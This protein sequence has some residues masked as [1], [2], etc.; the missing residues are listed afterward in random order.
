MAQSFDSIV[1][2]FL[3]YRVVSRFSF[4]V[5]IYVVALVAA[6]FSFWEIGG[7]LFAYGIATMAFGGAAQRSMRRRGP[8]KVIARG[9]ACKLMSN[10]LIGLALLGAL[11]NIAHADIAML[12]LAQILGGIG[13]CFAAVGDGSYLNHA[14]KALNAESEIQVKA[15]A[16]SSSYMFIAFLFAGCAGAVLYKVVPSLP[17]FLTS[18]A[19]M[20]AAI[21]AVMWLAVQAPGASSAADN[22]ADASNSK[23]PAAL[24]AISWIN[25]FG[26]AFLRAI[27]LTLQLLILPVWLFLGLQIEVLYFGLIFGLYTFAGFL[28][29]RFY[30]K[31]SER[32][33]QKGAIAFVVATTLM[34]MLAL[35]LS[36]TVLLTLAAPIGMFCIAGMLRP[37]FLPVLNQAKTVDGRAINAVPR[38]ER[39]FGALSAASFLAVG[40]AFHAGCSPQQIVLG[41]TVLA[42]LALALGLM[43]FQGRSGSAHPS[44]SND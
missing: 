6:E 39:L 16:K 36:Q 20:L 8:A 41:S 40:I 19:N 15:Q 34:S 37:A 31:L 21:I 24:S 28:G 27:V 43:L 38:A 1:R 3:I 32:V 11:R 4:Y 10:A 22:P 23:R 5:P 13:Y 2:R 33:S 30:P 26:Y 42:A 14:A 17:F 29:G 35:G 18:A 12:V 9:E 25:L 44:S 7:V